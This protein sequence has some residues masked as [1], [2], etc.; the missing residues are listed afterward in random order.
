MPIRF[1]TRSESISDD[2]LAR[3]VI[4]REN[5]LANYQANLNGYKQQVA[6]LHDLP[7][8]PNNLL[9][10]KGKQHEQILAMGASEGD[11]QLASKLNYRDR[12]NHL[13]FT[14]AAEMWKCEVTHKTLVSQITDEAKF[15]AAVERVRAKV[16]N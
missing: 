6:A 1:L 2:D 8:W 12:L 7:P 5:E 15:L 16:V 13:A 3:A 14:E 10:F 9:Q 4:D 11:A